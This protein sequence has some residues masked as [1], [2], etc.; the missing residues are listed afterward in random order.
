MTINSTVYYLNVKLTHTPHSCWVAGADSVPQATARK[1]TKDA[2]IISINNREPLE[3]NILRDLGFRKIHSNYYIFAYVCWVLHTLWLTDSSCN[4]LKGERGKDTLKAAAFS[5]SS[6]DSFLSLTIGRK[7]SLGP[8][9]LPRVIVSLLQDASPFTLGLFSF[10]PLHNCALSFFFVLGNSP[11]FHN[12]A[13][14]SLALLFSIEL[15]L[16]SLGP[17]ALLL[18]LP[19]S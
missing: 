5:Q 7:H 6:V 4:C 9:P 3:V 16:H 14:F 11:W 15:W 19:T 18:V 8:T 1:E 10:F 12:F 17:L 2:R 13:S